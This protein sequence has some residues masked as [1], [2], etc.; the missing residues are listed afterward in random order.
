ME[1]SFD[2]KEGKPFSQSEINQ[3]KR[4]LNAE[5]FQN[6]YNIHN[7]SHSFDENKN[8]I[9][10]EKNNDEEIKQNDNKFIN[11]NHIKETEENNMIHSDS[12]ILIKKDIIINNKN[13]EKNE[14]S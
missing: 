9:E 8:N 4:D 3:L 5:K 12:E 1:I 7:N 6:I 11:S 14:E 2:E 13:N 10:E